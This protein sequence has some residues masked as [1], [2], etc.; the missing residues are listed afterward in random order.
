MCFLAFL[1]KIW[2]PQNFIFASENGQK[3][4]DVQEKCRKWKVTEMTTAE[5]GMFFKMVTFQ[6]S[7]NNPIFRSKNALFRSLM[8]SISNL[9]YT[10]PKKIMKIMGLVNWNLFD[11]IPEIVVC[12]CY[13]IPPVLMG[14]Y[15]IYLR[16]HI[17]SDNFLSLAFGGRFSHKLDHFLPN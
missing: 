7:A 2:D 11:A 6:K 14:L 12:Y 1:T 5:D 3:P 8:D 9:N 17:G 4:S 15:L 16:K 13:S 10:Q